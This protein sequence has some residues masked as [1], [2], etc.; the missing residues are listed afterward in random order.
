MNTILRERE[1]GKRIAQKALKA[2]LLRNTCYN[3]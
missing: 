3:E 2:V 1:E